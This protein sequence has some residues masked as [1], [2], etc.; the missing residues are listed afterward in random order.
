[1][2]RTR[3][4]PERPAPENVASIFSN[5]PN[6][7][8]AMAWDIL[9]DWLLKPGPLGEVPEELK[10]L[11]DEVTAPGKTTAPDNVIAFKPRSNA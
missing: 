11:A 1:M 3:K 2:K 10:R 6:K 9:G 4:T 8:A 7:R 5:A